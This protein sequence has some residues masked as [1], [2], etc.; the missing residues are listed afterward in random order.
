MEAY[1]KTMSGLEFMVSQAP[2][3][4]APGTGTGVWVIRKQIRKKS[5]ANE[6]EVAVVGTYYV[7]GENVYMAPTVADVLGN[8]MV[9]LLLPTFQFTAP[10]NLTSSTQLAIASSLKKA[11]ST[12]ATM[13]DFSPALGHNYIPPKSKPLKPI[14]DSQIGISQASKETTP[15][16]D[17]NS[18]ILSGAKKSATS[19]DDSSTYLANR[20]LEESINISLRYGDEYMDENPITGAPGEFHLSSTGRRAA[21]IQKLVVPSAVKPGL[22]MP[23]K[24]TGE[25]EG[26]AKGFMKSR[27]DGLADFKGKKGEKSPRT[28][29]SGKVKR[30]K[31]KIGAVSPT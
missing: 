18:Q 4:T 7:V 11:F 22:Q 6:D 1:L 3:E 24:A 31:S 25:A 16:P 28:P 17:S 5:P 2:A 8:R 14:S 13:P 15:L 30:R 19:A 23:G 20:L 12:A 29:G 10:E 9:C 26:Q 27:T 21:E